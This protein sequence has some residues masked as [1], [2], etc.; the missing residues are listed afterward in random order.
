[1]GLKMIRNLDILF[2]LSLVSF[3]Q[4]QFGFIV[5]LIQAYSLYIVNSGKK[6]Y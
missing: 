3:H 2:G 6:M 4:F 1:M 5:T